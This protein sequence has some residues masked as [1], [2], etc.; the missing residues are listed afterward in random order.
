PTSRRGSGRPSSQ[1]S[2]S[3]NVVPGAPWDASLVV[4]RGTPGSSG[5]AL[6]RVGL[7][8]FRERRRGAAQRGGE[9]PPVALAGR[10]PGVRAPGLFEQHLHAGLQLVRGRRGV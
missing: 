3:P 2:S 9:P 4:A 6:G 5:L 1:P 10:L 8:R 7:L